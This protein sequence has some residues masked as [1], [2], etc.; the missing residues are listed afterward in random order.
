MP[1]LQ[2]YKMLNINDQISAFL[3]ALAETLLNKG[4]TLPSFD[5]LTVRLTE[6]NVR[7]LLNGNGLDQVGLL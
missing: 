7:R 3:A 4:I 1:N 6:D 2:L 5:F